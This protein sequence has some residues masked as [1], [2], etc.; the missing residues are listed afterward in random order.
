MAPLS[1][2][3][4]PSGGCDDEVPGSVSVVAGVASSVTHLA[5]HVTVPCHCT[6]VIESTACEGTPD[7]IECY[8]FP[9]CT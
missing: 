1:A 6:G 9:A 2:A 4:S 5:A 3:S 7:C 8:A